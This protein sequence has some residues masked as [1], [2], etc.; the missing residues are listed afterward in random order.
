MIAQAGYRCSSI[1][2]LIRR[3]RRRAGKEERGKGRVTYFFGRSGRQGTSNSFSPVGKEDR[4]KKGS[5]TPS[6]IASYRALERI[7]S[8]PAAHLQRHSRPKRRRGKKGSARNCFGTNTIVGGG[9]GR[10]RGA[11]QSG[12][13]NRGEGDVF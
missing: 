3:L 5:P 7:T 4:K 6:E 13:T 8:V 1:L 2:C 9:E 12:P 10:K 11:W